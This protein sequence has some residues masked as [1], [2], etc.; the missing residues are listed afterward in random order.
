[1]TCHWIRQ[2]VRHIGILDLVSISNTSPQTTCHSAPVSEILSKS[3]H[4]RQTK[5][6][7]MSIFK[8]ADLSRL[9]FYGSNN[10]F[11]AKPNYIT[12]YRS[13]ID[14]IA[15]NCLFFWENRVFLHS[16]NRQTNK[17][18]NRRTDEQMDRIDALGRSRERR[19]NN[20]FYFCT[21]QCRYFEYVHHSR[22]SKKYP[23]RAFEGYSIELP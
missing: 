5:N 19:L 1:M 2:N 10:G 7:V 13:S 16:G 12:F 6:D 9:G 18:T 23:P 11:F 22:H 14:T 15:L 20:I 3:D 8:M 4:P 21:V 17:Q